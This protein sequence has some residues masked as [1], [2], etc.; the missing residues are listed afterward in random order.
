MKRASRSAWSGVAIALGM[1]ACETFPIGAR[2]ADPSGQ[3]TAP[4]PLEELLTQVVSDWRPPG[5]EEKIRA[6]VRAYPKAKAEI[7]EFFKREYFETAQPSDLRVGAALSALAMLD[8]LTEED[9]RPLV[10]EMHRVAEIKEPTFA[11]DTVVRGGI[12][13]L[14]TSAEALKQ[15]E[16]ILSFFARDIYYAFP[17]GLD[18]LSEVGTGRAVPVLLGAQRR[19]AETHPGSA[20]I[21]HTDATMAAIKARELQQGREVRDKETPDWRGSQGSFSDREAAVGDADARLWQTGL[22]CMGMGLL[23]IGAVWVVWKRLRDPSR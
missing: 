5:F 1:L 23:A 8:P 3:S 10:E 4:V 2:A 17:D 22:V 16:F 19:L 14:K 12:Q 7:L 13:L 20:R 11:E 18:F 9:L 21:G 15:E 6:Q